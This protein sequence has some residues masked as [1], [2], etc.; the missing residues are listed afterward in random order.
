MAD[1]QLDDEEKKGGKGLI[2]IVLIVVAVL[3]LVGGTVGATLFFTG[4]FDPAPEEAAEAQI[5]QIESEAETAATE[6]AKQP[7]KIQLEAPKVEKFETVYF[8][9]E[10]E[11]IANLA[12]SRKVM[13]IK[14]AIMTHYDEQVVSNIEKHT[15]AIRSAIM[16]LMRQVSEQRL[17]EPA[18]RVEFAEDIRLAMNAILERN[19]DFG[20]IE[21][22]YF[23]EFI[24]Q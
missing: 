10:R 1:E 23:S 4:F 22:V 14:V 19:E 13:Q 7:A 12:N 9:L 2:K 3:V 11:M 18:F 6:A 24:V 20:G 17:E 15:F 5:Q 16:D 8:E 21:Q